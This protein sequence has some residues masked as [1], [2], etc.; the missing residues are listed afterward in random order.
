MKQ[1]TYNVMTVFEFEE[2]IAKVL[3]IV[4]HKVEVVANEEW[5][6]DTDHSYTNCQGK[7]DDWDRKSI[8][9][10]ISKKEYGQYG[11]YRWLNYLISIG[12]LEPGNYLITVSW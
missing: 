4:S 5:S 12:T 3:G 11:S 2:L 6:N 10:N 8:S 7:M 1:V 9:E